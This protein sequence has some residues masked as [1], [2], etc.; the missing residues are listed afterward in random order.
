[1]FDYA[2]PEVIVD[3]QWLA[4]HLD[5]SNICLIEG[6]I[7]SQAYDTGHIPGAVF[8]NLLTAFLLPN[9]QTNFDPV[10]LEELL[11]RSG[12]TNDTTIITYGDIPAIGAWIFWFLKVFGHHD[13]RILNGGRRKWIAE[14]RPLTAQQPVVKPSQYRLQN[15][16]IS[17]RASHEYVRESIRR[18]D[19]ILVDV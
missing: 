15:L 10:S 4:E 17:L 14:R 8:W 18:T 13:V 12:I 1:M 19:R 2:H 6:D 5:N 3:T 16:D 7:N 11:T 9:Y